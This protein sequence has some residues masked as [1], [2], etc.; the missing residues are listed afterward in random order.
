MIPIGRDLVRVLQN[1][2]RFVK[3]LIIITILSLNFTMTRHN[4]NENSQQI[5]MF[6]TKNQMQFHTSKRNLQRNESER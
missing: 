3:L 4:N 5:K 2:F 1:V 6:I